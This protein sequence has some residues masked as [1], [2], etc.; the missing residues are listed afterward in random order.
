MYIHTTNG[1]SVSD[2]RPTSHH[3]S[4]KTDIMQ[5]LDGP[6]PAWFWHTYRDHRPHPVLFY[7]AYLT[8][9]RVKHILGNIDTQLR[10]LSGLDIGLAHAIDILLRGRPG[11]AYHKYT[12]T[13]LQWSH[14]ERDGV[15]NHRRLY[16]LI[17]RLFRRRSKKAP[18]HGLCAR[19]S[20]V[21]G[22]FPAQVA[23]NAE[24]VSIW[25]RHHVT[26]VCILPKS[27][28]F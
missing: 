3:G 25:W 15:P 5:W 19:N 2:E 9:C 13:S 20:P 14:N 4:R 26:M 1:V 24:N 6:V 23:S 21:T 12:M 17:N 11:P 16:C 7:H 8:S 28:V 18:R 22:E 10:F 27:I